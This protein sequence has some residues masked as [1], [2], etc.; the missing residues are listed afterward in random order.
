MTEFVVEI[1]WP[2]QGPDLNQK[3]L[4]LDVLEQR[5]WAVSALTNAFLEE[6]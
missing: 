5:L 2:A 6:W 4:F 1:D 3:Q